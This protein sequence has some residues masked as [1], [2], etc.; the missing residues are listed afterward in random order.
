M[1]FRLH[2]IRLVGLE[3]ALLL[4]AAMLVMVVKLLLEFRC[5]VMFLMLRGLCSPTMTEVGTGPWLLSVVMVLEVPCR[6]TALW[7]L[8]SVL[9]PSPHEMDLILS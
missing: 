6:A 7:H 9:L 5:P 8:V 2:R 1:A 4:V 3:A